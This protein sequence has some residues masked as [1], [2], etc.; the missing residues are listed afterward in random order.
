MVKSVSRAQFQAFPRP[1]PPSAYGYLVEEHEWYA[2]DSEHTLGLLFR[3]KQ[4]DEWGYVILQP[5]ADLL[6]RWV[7]GDYTFSVK[8]EARR[9]LLCDMERLSRELERSG[10]TDV[11]VNLAR[12]IRPKDPFVPVVNRSSLN[13][14]FQVVATHGSHSPARGMI[15]E[16]FRSYTDRDGNFVQQFQTT[17]FDARIWE[18]YLHAYLTDRGFA[19]LP[20]V[21][22]DY[23]VSKGRE[24]VAIEAV[25]ANPTQGLGG[26]QTEGRTFLHQAPCGALLG[27]SSW[28]GHRL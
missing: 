25:T 23:V 21:S 26:V 24:P 7:G 11:L 6:F 1:L 9:N 18:L 19:F 20:T 28:A 14:L 2:D 8:E 3:D 10:A 12:A 17:G 22:P 4:D 16:V 5:D 13:R 15:R 27:T